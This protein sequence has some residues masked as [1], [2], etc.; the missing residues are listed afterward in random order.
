M[1][2]RITLVVAAVLFLA[3]PATADVDAHLQEAAELVRDVG[4]DARVMMSKVPRACR[5]LRRAANAAEEA[6]NEADIARIDAAKKHCRRAVQAVQ[7]GN[8][9]RAAHRV[10]RMLAVIDGEQ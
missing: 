9:T 10:E 5:I 8:A 3:A 2:H 7:N 4:N 1:K 6:E